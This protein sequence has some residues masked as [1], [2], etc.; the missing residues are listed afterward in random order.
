[1]CQFMNY[2]RTTS[3]TVDCAEVLCACCIGCT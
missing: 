2:N 3:P 1:M